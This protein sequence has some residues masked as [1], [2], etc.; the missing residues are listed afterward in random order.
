MT[1]LEKLSDDDVKA[2]LDTA[3]LCSNGSRSEM[4]VRLAL[5]THKSTEAK[6]GR[7]QLNDLS[8][9]ELKSVSDGLGLQTEAA[10]REELLESLE[11]S[12]L[13]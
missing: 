5:F 12:L 1:R 3:G 10:T 11:K 6:A 8:L 9:D 2:R 13:S 4:I 7:L